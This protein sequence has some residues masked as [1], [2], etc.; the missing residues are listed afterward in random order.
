MQTEIRPFVLALLGKKAPLPRGFDDV[1]DFIDAGIVDSIGIIKFVL[2]L[3]SR[4][5]IEISE[6]D[7][8]SDEFRTVQGLVE[9]L[10]RKTADTAG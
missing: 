2:E 10:R 3:E 9:I 6:A 1:T 5:E 7:I 8:E 4:F